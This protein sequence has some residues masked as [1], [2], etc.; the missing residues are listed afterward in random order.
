MTI[1]KAI[2]ISSEGFEAGVLVNATN[3]IVI[4]A[5]ADAEIILRGLDFEG[6]NTGLNGVR[7]LAGRSLIVDNCQIRNFGNIAA[8]NGNGINFSPAGASELFVNN[9]TISN[10]GV[11]G[12]VVSPTGAGSARV[13][14][15]NTRI[16]DNAAGVRLDGATTTSGINASI[17]DTIIAD[18]TGNGFQALGDANSPLKVMIDN[19]VIS[20]N[21]SNG[22]RVGTNSTV[23]L[24]SSVVANNAGTGLVPF[25][26]GQILSYGNNQ[27]NGNGT[28]GAPTATIP[29]L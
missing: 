16:V 15:E 22:V 12:I 21:Q 27:V 8:G 10:S 3:G 26:G 13:T 6:L 14:I 29:L 7:F 2:T 1:T 18:N 9:T 25:G 20:E 23:R 28:D 5:P 4:N 19:S 11:N 24:G 17:T